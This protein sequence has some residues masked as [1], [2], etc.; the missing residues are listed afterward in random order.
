MTAEPSPEPQARRP[1]AWLVVATV[2]LA[3][4]CLAM[5]VT[6]TSQWGHYLIDQGEWLSLLG[7]AFVAGSGVA[8][9]RQRRLRVSL[10][11]VFP[12]LLYP[13]ITQGDQIIDNLSIGWMRLITHVLLAALFGAPVAAIVMA[14]RHAL[15]PVP[16]EAAMQSRWAALFPGL[17]LIA[18]GR[19]REGGAMLAVA[20]IGIQFFVAHLLLG[21]LM[22][23][24]LVLMLLATVA[25]GSRPEAERGPRISEA[26][27]LGVV[28][29]GVLLS[30]ALYVGFKNRPG[31]YQG[32]PS[33]LLD[34]SQNAAGYGFD[35]IAVPPGPVAAPPPEVAQ[36]VREALS[37]EARALEKLLAG[38]YIVDRAYTHD[39]HNALFLRNW[40]VMPGYRGVAL[41]RID[42][43]RR[44]AAAAQAGA[45]A[46]RVRLSDADPL[47]ALL[48]DMR[49]YVAF[50]FERARVI[51]RLSADFERT[52]AGLQHAAHIYEG[53]G[54]L[55]GLGLARLLDKH[56]AT[57]GAPAVAPL[58]VE[59]ERVSASIHEAYANRIVGF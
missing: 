13:V 57:L 26:S 21:T 30:L 4:A 49:E 43:A 41:E 36:G 3:L 34:P 9:Y 47:A 11:F 52:Q 27:A 53:E 45:A 55:V 20:L 58:A 39:F 17:G 18:R 28:A 24:T 48:D 32:S 38:Y 8:L 22:V 37:S 15:A 1:P 25:W 6:E 16:G 19:G 23:A 51:E 40:P 31:A 5:A 14:A 12:W 46:A 44:L 10:P 50:N 54:K 59:F 29:V 35:H 2:G 56:R 42:E 7:L 33:Y